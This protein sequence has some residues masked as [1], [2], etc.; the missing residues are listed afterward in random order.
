MKS[1]S[2][3]ECTKIPSSSH[4]HLLIFTR[5]LELRRLARAMKSL[6]TQSQSLKSGV[7]LK[8]I[9]AK[10][11]GFLNETSTKGG[12]SFIRTESFFKS[13]HTSHSNSILITILY[14]IHKP[15]ID[16]R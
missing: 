1:C 15:L 16:G 5:S 13:L 12:T 6:P 8:S 9:L 11:F 14:Q 2:T 10:S 3:I 4:I 7:F